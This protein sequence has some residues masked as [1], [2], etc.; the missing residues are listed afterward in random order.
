MQIHQDQA[1]SQ[2]RTPFSSR[3]SPRQFVRASTLVTS[4]ATTT[5]EPLWRQLLRAHMDR[6]GAMSALIAESYGLSHL[7]AEAIGQ[8]ARLH[9]LGKVFVP[10]AILQK[11]SGL[12]EN[13]RA[14]MESH[15]QWGFEALARVAEGDP[16]MELA[17]EV[18]L[19]HHERWDG[20]GYPSGLVGTQIGLAARIVSVCDVYD[21]LR[22]ERSYKP[23]YDH[24][25]AIAILADDER[26]SERQFDPEVLVLFL[27]NQERCRE[28]F[29]GLWAFECRIGLAASTDI[30]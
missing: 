5:G 9:D 25:R 2:I 19:Q 16:A 20:G 12:T 17:A 30:H 3:T 8:A 14:T 27:A 7:D 21:S 11:P 13:E 1:T 23:A 24:E 28:I 4:G 29:D 22:S 18:A 15:C 26:R 6:V 10:Q